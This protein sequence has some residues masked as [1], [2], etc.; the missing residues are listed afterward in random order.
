M[1]ASNR[2]LCVFK[3]GKHKFEVIANQGAILQ[4]RDGKIPIHNVLLIDQVFT[5]STRGDIANPGDLETV[6]GTE[7][8]SKCCEEIVKRGDIQY[9]ASERK[10]FTED[11]TK[12]I[13][14]Y[15]NKNYVDPKTKLPHPADRIANCMKQCHIRVDPNGDT[16]RQG[17]EAVKKMRG[18]LMFAKAVAITAKLTIKH[19][20]TGKC[21]NLIRQ[22]ANVLQDEWTGTG[23][24]YTL[25]LSKADFNALQAALMKPTNGDYNFQ[26]LDE[27][28]NTGDA[29]EVEQGGKKG[30]R[31]KKKEKKKKKHG[32]VEQKT[33]DEPE[34][35]DKP[36]GRKKKKKNKGKSGK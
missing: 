3:S 1:A 35:D 16:K 8:V 24:V 9:T 2:Q 6:F 27:D 23:C 18:K 30:K 12:E 15:I 26:I 34:E 20:H 21:T 19:E 11:K 4:Y 14:Y 7:D 28:G 10:K 31:R 32:N 13:V 33:N 5:N 36:S 29:E 25:E 17:E 22:M